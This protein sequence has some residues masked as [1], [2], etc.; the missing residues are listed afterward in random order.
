MVQ[1]ILRLGVYRNLPFL[2]LLTN[3]ML[4]RSMCIFLILQMDNGLSI[5]H[6]VVFQHVEPIMRY[7]MMPLFYLF[8]EGYLLKK[9]H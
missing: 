3:Q 9:K 5:K 8:T 7:G 1:L 4:R 2:S 6:Q